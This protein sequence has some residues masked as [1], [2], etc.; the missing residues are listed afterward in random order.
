MSALRRGA[1]N[2]GATVKATVIY[3]DACRA[4]DWQNSDEIAAKPGDFLR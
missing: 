2:I 3:E 1:T 4:F